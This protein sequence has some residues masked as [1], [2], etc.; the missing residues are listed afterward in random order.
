MTYRRFKYESLLYLLA[1]LIA[2][3]LR[4]IQLGAMPLADAE[5]APALQA[6]RLSQGENPAL[7]PHPFYILF[8]S[9]LFFLYGGGT[10][11]LARFIPALTGSLLVFAPLLFDNR[12]KPRPGLLLAFFLA[13]DPGLVAI[14]RQA[15]SPIL[16]ITFLIFTF[17]FPNKNRSLLASIFAALTLLSGPPI[18]LGM[19]G[20]GIAWMI[21]QIFNRSKVSLFNV[22]SFKFSNLIPFLIAFVVAGTLFFS[23]PS[24][25]GAAFA[26]IPAFING[27]LNPSDVTP[28]RILLSIL[29]YQPF[30]LVLAVIALI[31]G[32]MRGIQRIIFL[33]I[34]L[35]VSLLLVIFLPSRQ[36]AD[37]AWTLIPLSVLAS[38]EFARSFNIFPEERREVAGVVLLTVFIWVFAWMGFSGM[39]WF[40]S[41]SQEYILRLW[42]FVGSLVLLVLSLLLVAAGWSVRTARF[43]GIWGL[44]IALGALSLSGAFGSAGL[45]GSNFP[46]LWW[47]PSAPA[48]ADLLRATVREVSEFG[49][50]HDTS[51]PVVIAGLNSPSL[52]W[53]LREHNVRVVGSLDASSAPEFVVTPFETDPV[54]VAGYRG[55]DFTWRQTPLWVGADPGT[56]FRWI[57]LRDMPQ[58]GETIILWAR[59]D[60]FLDR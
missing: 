40:P 41:D 9:V 28:G 6:L 17:G 47:L 56:W 59:D 55:Q 50:G 53:T 43:G 42:M 10:D 25:I 48:Q 14:S 16:A 46:E 36:V 2:I 52:E 11:F 54:L 5:A 31:R 1:F 4:F 49:V 44:A 60:L 34:W 45:R 19:L 24:G 32:W 26:S 3:T 15:A 35:L 18:W 8:T 21:F 13:L 38:L 27:W 51:A 30:I 12:I 33:S 20:L 57:A 29:I 58:Y 7:A 22:Q 39:I 37:L 23:A